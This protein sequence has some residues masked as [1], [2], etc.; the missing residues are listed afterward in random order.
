MTKKKQLHVQ[1][2]GLIDSLDLCHPRHSKSPSSHIRDRYWGCLSRW[3]YQ[4]DTQS[5]RSAI[6]SKY[7]GHKPI[8]TQD[9]GLLLA[10]KKL[11]D[12]GINT[13][14]SSI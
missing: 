9:I 1:Y 13:T 10:L 14:D 5:H 6:S 2:V 7:R 4:E 8:T 12:N 3:M 11:E